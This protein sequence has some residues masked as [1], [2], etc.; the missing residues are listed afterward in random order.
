MVLKMCSDW[1]APM[2]E[3]KVMILGAELFRSVVSEKRPAWIGGILEAVLV[4]ARWDFLGFG[5]RML[6]ICRDRSAW[7]TAESLFHELRQASL[8]F[9]IEGSPVECAIVDLLEISA[10]VVFNA[11]GARP[12]FD[13]HAGERVLPRVWQIMRFIE[14]EPGREELL[15]RVEEALWRGAKKV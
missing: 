13:A 14:R 3:G 15:C 12:G 5:Q 8:S 2:D 9:E 4:A 7:G 10:K 11:S 1:R 6:A